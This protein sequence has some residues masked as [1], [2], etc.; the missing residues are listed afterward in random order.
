MTMELI[1]STTITS[2]T[3]SISLNGIPLD[4]KDLILFVSAR[5]NADNQYLNIGINGSIQSFNQIDL[6]GTGGGRSTNI[7][8]DSIVQTMS[9]LNSWTANTFS[10]VVLYFPNYTSSNAKSISF[11]GVTE[12]DS[13]T[14]YSA[15]KAMSWPNASA[16]SSLSIHAVSGTSLV[17][18]T[19]A[20]L[21]K[22]S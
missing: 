17:A 7:R 6:F 11:E 18:Q 3:T 15:I 10:N 19:S 21:Y 16:I 9:N 22:I 1:Q 12:N 5:T 8:T 2:P 4:G 13:S 14:A 20:S